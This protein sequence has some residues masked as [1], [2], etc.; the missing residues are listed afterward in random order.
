VW[1]STTDQIF[2]IRQIQKKKLECSE[3]VHQLFIYFKKA[4]ESVRKEGMYNI[5]IEFGVKV[6]LLVV[7]QFKMC[8]NETYNKVSIGKYSLPDFPIQ[9]DVVKGDVLNPLLF[10]FAAEY[11]IRKVKENQVGLELNGTYQMLVCADDMKLQGDN[12]GTIK[13]N[14]EP[15][16]NASNEVG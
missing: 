1:V 12:I 11:T 8:L 10:N 9:N 5:L 15:L 2:C 4:Y 6:K 16:I 13:R 7:R 3:T 14:T